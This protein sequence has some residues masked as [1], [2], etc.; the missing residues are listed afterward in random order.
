M[1]RTSLPDKY[2]GIEGF[3]I[4]NTKAELGY[5][6]PQTSA[7]KKETF[8]Q[9][10]NAMFLEEHPH[11][12]DEFEEFMRHLKVLLERYLKDPDAGMELGYVLPAHDES[13]GWDSATLRLHDSVMEAFRAHEQYLY[14][15]GLKDPFKTDIES[16][17]L[18]NT[19]SLQRGLGDLITHK[20]QFD[21]YM[22]YPA[23]F[24]RSG[25]VSAG[26]STLRVLN[27]IWSDTEVESESVGISA[28]SV[29]DLLRKNTIDRGAIDPSRR[30]ENRFTIC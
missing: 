5:I 1:D 9:L 11:F 27:L 30:V 21:A 29:F 12:E 10:G 16:E 17:R 13:R 18:Q 24:F 2:K 6:D 8:P 25:P 7:A 22:Y 3:Y 26:E 23:L 15:K 28:R 19:R 20:D 14:E 4:L